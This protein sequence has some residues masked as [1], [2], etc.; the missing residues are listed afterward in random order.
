MIDYSYIIVIGLP[1]VYLL[2]CVYLL[3]PS[4]SC[5][6]YRKLCTNIHDNEEIDEEID[7]EMGANQDYNEFKEDENTADHT[8]EEEDVP[9]SYN[10]LYPA[11]V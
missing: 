9:K 4:K 8:E 3:I 7:E 6:L 5:F 10:E 2:R 11:S 1:V